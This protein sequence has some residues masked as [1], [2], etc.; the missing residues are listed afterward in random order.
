M[1]SG[2]GQTNLNKVPYQGRFVELMP[3]HPHVP[4]SFAP[5]DVAEA[6]AAHAHLPCRSGHECNTDAGAHQIEQRKRVSRL[7][8]D[9][10]AEAG[11]AA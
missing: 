7:L 9:A 6:Y 3:G 2:H 11:A 10:R 8:H 4:L 5:V 1:R